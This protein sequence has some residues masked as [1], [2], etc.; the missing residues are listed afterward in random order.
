[1]KYTSLKCILLFLPIFLNVEGNKLFDKNLCFEKN[2][3]LKNKKCGLVKTFFLPRSQGSNTARRLAGWKKYMFLDKKFAHGSA[4][5]T[6]EYSNSFDSERIAKYLFGNSCLRFTGSQVPDRNENG[7]ILADYF[8]LPTT[9]T[10]E[11]CVKPRIEN[12]IVDLTYKLDLDPWCSGL[13]WQVFFPIVI[14]YWNLNLKILESNINA[15]SANFPECYMSKNATGAVCSLEEALKGEQTF[16]D[17]I[18]PWDFGKF[19]ICKRKK[20]GIADIDL[21]LGYH[22]FYNPC[23]HLSLFLVTTIP[24]GNRPESRILFEPIVGNG[25]NWEFGGGSTGHITFYSSGCRNLSLQ[26]FGHVSYRF[27]T[28]QIRSFDLCNNGKFSRYLLLK[29]F[30]EKNNYKD[31]LLNAIDF[32]TKSVRV[33]NLVRGDGSIKLTYEYGPFAFDAGYNIY[34]K[35]QE[36]LNIIND[37]FPSDNN[38]R[39]FGIKGTEGV[40]AKIFDVQDQEVIS[41]ITLNSTQD[42]A[43]ITKGGTVDNPEPITVLEPD[44][45][46]IT[47]DSKESSDPSD[48]TLAKQS[49]PPVLISKKDFNICSAIVPAQI[50]HK[51]FAHISCINLATA[52]QYQ[53]GIGGEVEFDKSKQLTGLSQWGIWVKAGIFF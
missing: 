44:S 32:V 7:D 33:G 10:G 52:W 29:E 26:W 47:W 31:M 48:L 38:N 9:F 39:K 43:T 49:D 42:D 34:G 1:M 18:S 4:S 45:F 37:I 13:Y 21:L 8:G 30:D 17:M 28:F 15:D 5:M 41:K 3:K 40:C 27:K 22:A 24:G 50:T 35:T 23:Y 2:K 19:P 51:F 12:F 53:F 25:K 20:S 36:K 16:G 14:T 11:M 46:A 6:F